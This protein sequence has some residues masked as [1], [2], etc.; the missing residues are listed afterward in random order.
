[1][2]E[3]NNDSCP[4]EQET[5]IS[6]ARNQTFWDAL[7][8]V[9]TPN[10]NRIVGIFLILI[11]LIGGII[12][13]FRRLSGPSHPDIKRISSIDIRQLTVY[14]FAFDIITQILEEQGENISVSILFGG[15]LPTN[16]SKEVLYRA[17]L[18]I[19]YGVTLPKLSEDYYSIKDNTITLT[20]PPPSING[21]PQLVTNEKCDTKVIDS[22]YRK[23]PWYKFLKTRPNI[24]EII[25]KAR[26]Q[27][28]D[29]APKLVKEF[30]LDEMVRKR[31][32]K[33]VQAMLKS[34][35]PDCDIFVR[36]NDE[37]MRSSS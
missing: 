26:I 29:E 31:S 32:K 17:C 36:F 28:Q 15:I 9:F 21:E 30:A 10:F 18:E 4:P 24:D 3:N 11:I 14:K 34:F 22:R 5:N 1:M 23:V 37:D 6:G 33:L 7:A 25:K 12:F 35:F 16:Q 20:L 19:E 2:N 27:L 8:Q 13:V